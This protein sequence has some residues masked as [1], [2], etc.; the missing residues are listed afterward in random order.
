MRREHPD[1]A[2]V[3]RDPLGRDHAQAVAVKRAFQAVQRKV[4]PM[5]V[6]DDVELTLC[7]T[8]RVMEVDGDQPPGREGGRDAS[9]QGVEVVHMGESVAD[10]DQVSRVRSRSVRQAGDD[11]P[12]RGQSDATGSPLEPSTSRPPGSSAWQRSLDQSHPGIVRRGRHRVSVCR[13]GSLRT[14]TE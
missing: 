3:V 9:D 2:P 4:A 5:G 1:R 6:G 10:E 7:E 14:R 13:A 8:Q 11:A 12:G